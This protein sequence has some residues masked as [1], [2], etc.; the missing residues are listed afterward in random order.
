MRP[1]MLLGGAMFIFNKLNKM[2]G[3]NDKVPIVAE[4]ITARWAYEALTVYQFKDNQFERQFYN[5]EK[6]ISVSDFKQVYY[7]P[8]L[9]DIV[10]NCV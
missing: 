7:I 3:S 8:E 10:D 4:L 5:L 6:Q 1:H 2:I 9:E